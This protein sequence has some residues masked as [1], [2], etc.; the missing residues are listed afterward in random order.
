MKPANSV[1]SGYGTSIF[2]VMSQLAKE[3]GTINLGQGF[4]DTEGP[5]DI[6]RVAAETVIAGPNQYPPMM[7][8]PELRQAM[9]EHDR[10][11]YGLDLDWQREVLVTSGGGEALAD[12]IFG[13]VE[14]GD[15]VVLIE[16]LYEMYLPLVRRAGGLA[17]MVRIEPPAWEL[18]RAALE[19]ACNERTKM[20]LLNTPHNPS[21]KV[22][23]RDEL[24]FIAD[25]AKRWDAYV[26]CDEVFEHIVF[27][28]AAHVPLMTL[29]GMRE[30]CLRIASA[31]KIFSMTG[32]KVGFIVGAPAV[33]APVA[34]AHQFITFTTPPNLQKAVAYGLGKEDG[35]FSSLAGDL[36]RKRDL[37]A[38]G[39]R[40]AGFKVLT[41]QGTYFVN[42]DIRSV[43]FNGDDVA[44]CRHITTEAGVTALPVSALYSGDDVR[45]FVRFACCKQDDILVEAA[46]RLKRHFAT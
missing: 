22:F 23:D 36:E 25:L 19:A 15:E 39:L 7:G 32:W 3:H 40:D 12:C 11:F 21:G 37:L 6:R 27:Q 14:P 46:A 28:G 41:S 10:R 34:K 5:E 4:P 13:I 1:F 43:G 26:M 29:P 31:G 20:I 33:L 17:R 45:H 18:P 9:A 38:G 2:E 35:Y 16:P 42:V 24:G 8:L 44:F 30:R